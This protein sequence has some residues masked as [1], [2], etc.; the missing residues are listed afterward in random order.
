[1]CVDDLLLHING[2]T[3]LRL[4]TLVPY[5]IPPLRKDMP[6][7]TKEDITWSCISPALDLTTILP[8]TYNASFTIYHLGAYVN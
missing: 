7:I 8:T 2:A 6:L 1:M 5:C 3:R 4:L